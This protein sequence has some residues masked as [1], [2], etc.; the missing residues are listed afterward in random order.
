MVTSGRDATRPRNRKPDQYDRMGDQRTSPAPARN[1]SPSAPDKMGYVGGVKTTPGS[2]E[3]ATR[4]VGRHPDEV[5]RSG[6][7]T[8]ASNRTDHFTGPGPSGA[9]GGPRAPRNHARGYK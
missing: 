1:G 3:G 4:S 5:D 8:W 6:V 2:G 7:K 9:S